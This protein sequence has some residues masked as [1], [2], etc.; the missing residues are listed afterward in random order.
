[1]VVDR[2]TALGL[3]MGQLADYVAVVGLAQIDLDK[4]FGSAPTILNAFRASPEAKP[5]G[6]TAWD[7]ALL[8]ALYT[9]NRSGRMALA[10]VQGMVLASFDASN[11][12]RPV[13][14]AGRAAPPAPW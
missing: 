7:L 5:A 9:V 13:L 11:A 6:V 8:H 3:T 2:K 14:S 10:D 1:M 4:D 12:L